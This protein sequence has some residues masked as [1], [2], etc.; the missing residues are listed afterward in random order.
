[1]G[2]KNVIACLQDQLTIGD[3]VEV[4]TVT[5]NALQYL[6]VSPNGVFRT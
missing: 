5:Q 1:M 2:I 6:A 3:E 4:T